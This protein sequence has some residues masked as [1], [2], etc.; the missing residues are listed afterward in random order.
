MRIAV[1]QGAAKLLEPAANLA[2]LDRLATACAL[3]QAELL[4]AP[5]LFLTGYNLGADA[6]SVAEAIDGP[7]SRAAAAIAR[8]HRIALIYGYPEAGGDGIFNSAILIGP[9][10]AILANYRKAHLFGDLE[11]RCFVPGADLVTARLGALTI[12]L[13]ICYDIEFPEFIRALVLKGAD[14]IAVP[15]CL[16]PPYWEIPTTIVRARAYENQVFV[17]YANHVG[18]ERDLD[19]IGLSGIAGP[20]GRDIAR[21]GERNETLLFAEVDPAHYAESRS[22]N[23]YL[24]DRRPELYRALVGPE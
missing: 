22:H 20:D 21:A 16:T 4:I 24:R 2:R 17:A 10:G 9:D 6:P 23:T 3:E 5:E 7:S 19:Y 18:S 8:H 11:R 15:T 12:G 1:F 14:L 13:A